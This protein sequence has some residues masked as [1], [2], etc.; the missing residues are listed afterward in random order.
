MG[1]ANTLQAFEN[2]VLRKI[3]GLHKA[4]VSETS[5]CY[6]IRNFVIYRGHLELLG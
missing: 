4:E 5:G 2:K 1:E 3:L 6:I